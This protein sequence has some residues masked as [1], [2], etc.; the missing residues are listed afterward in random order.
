VARELTVEGEGATTSTAGIPAS[1]VA[2]TRDEGS[3][4]G[5]SIEVSERVRVGGGGRISAASQGSGSPGDIVIRDTQQ[6]LVDGGTISAESRGLA[7]GGEQ[8]PGSIRIENADRVTVENGGTISV[9]G[10]AGGDGGDLSVV[11][12]RV[13][14]TLGGTLSAT[15]EAFGGNITLLASNL[16]YLLGAEVTASAEGGTSGPVPEGARGGNVTI[17]PPVVVINRS[18]ITAKGEGIADGGNFQVTADAFLLSGDSTIDVSSDF[19]VQGTV[20]IDAPDAEISGELAS[21]PADFTDAS[22]LLREAC[23][24]RDA[25]LGSFTVRGEGRVLAPPDAPLP[26]DTG[27]PADVAGCEEP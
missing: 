10:L 2:E 6:V 16:V 22:A 26:A 18:T 11:G 27:A 25:P 13:I 20:I 24:V 8:Q 4:G 23:A 9:R 17:D 12:S 21:L 15:A 19:G 3:A 1:L 5:I 14:E 7:L